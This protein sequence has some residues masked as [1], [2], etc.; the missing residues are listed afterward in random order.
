MSTKFIKDGSCFSLFKD[1]SLDIQDQL[2]P[3]N[4]VI[5][6]NPMTKS[7]Y[8][9]SA[10]DFELPN[11]LYGDTVPKAERI[12][13]TFMDRSQSTGVLLSGEK[14]SGKSLLAKTISVFASKIGIP[15][16]MI[17]ADWHG[18]DFNKLIQD[19]SQPCV[20]LFDEFEK[21]YGRD[22]QEAIL[23][24]LD[25]VFPT[26]KLFV[27]T[28][29]DKWKINDH[30]TNRPGR[31][32][33]AL[34]YEG[35]DCD[36]IS[37]YCNDNLNNKDNVSQ[38]CNLASTFE[39]FNFDMLKAVVEEMNRYKE[40]AFEVIKMLNASPM[41]GSNVK[42][43]VEMFVNGI[44]LKDAESCISYSNKVTCN[45]LNVATFELR[46]MLNN[47]DSDTEWN[48][49]D[50][51]QEYMTKYEPLIGRFTYNFEE[52][53]DKYILILSRSLEDAFTFD[54]FAEKFI[55]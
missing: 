2:P 16:I 13:N 25:G 52:D 42:Y 28:C 10:D 23:T 47:S 39:H 5:K 3:R 33:Y 17:N 29:N 41:R 54:K 4:Y 30:M 26:K 32:Y 9:D 45:P 37:E 15:T 53:N 43:D 35:L 50:F 7:F 18:E 14:G 36:F 20:V 38:V 51:H 19:I 27:F 44:K 8:L 24:L 55:V 34:E 21:V 40:T 11:K 48:Y 46:Y 1:E 22:E 6:Q 12:L 31:I 49:V